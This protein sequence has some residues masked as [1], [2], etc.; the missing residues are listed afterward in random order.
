MWWSCE[1]YLGTLKL[2]KRPSRCQFKWEMVWRRFEVL[3]APAAWWMGR[4]FDGN[5]KVRLMTC[6]VGA[7]AGGQKNGNGLWYVPRIECGLREWVW[8]R[9]IMKVKHIHHNVCYSGLE[10]EIAKCFFSIKALA[11]WGGHGDRFQSG[12]KQKLHIFL[13]RHVVWKNAFGCS[14]CVCSH[15]FWS[16]FWNFLSKNGFTPKQGNRDPC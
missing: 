13:R 1:F 9:N 12:Q 14:E 15:L 6:R 8:I 16:T 2:E 3:R 10:F 11:G 4:K 7:G 5:K